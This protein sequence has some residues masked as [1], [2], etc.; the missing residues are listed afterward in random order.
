MATSTSETGG[1]TRGKV[2]AKGK[3]GKPKAAPTSHLARRELELVVLFGRQGGCLNAQGALVRGR[4]PQRGAPRARRAEQAGGGRVAAACVQR[5][6]GL[7]EAAREY[8]R[9]LQASQQ[10]CRTRVLDWQRAEQKAGQ[11]YLYSLFWS[12]GRVGA[13]AGV[14]TVPGTRDPGERASV[15]GKA[16][17]GCLTAASTTATG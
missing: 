9:L 10:A 8:G 17:G 5:R 11:A 13:S 7:R 15:L 14:W 12:R 3:Q 4:L 2:S 6:V 1:T 16:A